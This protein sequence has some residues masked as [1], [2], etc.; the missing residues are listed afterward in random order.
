MTQ[1][2]GIKGHS[3][4]GNDPHSVIECLKWVSL[5]ENHP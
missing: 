1:A 2:A 3:L 5:K 4:Q